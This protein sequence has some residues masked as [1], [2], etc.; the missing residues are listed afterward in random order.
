[1]FLP[2]YQS[3]LLMSYNLG[4]HLMHCL[5]NIEGINLP[6]IF[7]LLKSITE[8]S[9]NTLVASC[10]TWVC[11]Y[12]DLTLYMLVTQF[13]LGK[14]GYKHRKCSIFAQNTRHFASVYYIMLCFYAVCIISMVLLIYYDRQYI[15]PEYY[16]K[17]IKCADNYEGMHVAIPLHQ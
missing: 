5:C 12:V 3:V 10:I 13:A 6:F 9:M 7:I 11:V 14:L 1:M 2:L 8:W 15:Q 17:W 4:I 16:Y